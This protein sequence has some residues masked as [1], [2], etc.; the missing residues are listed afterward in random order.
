M[1]TSDTWLNSKNVYFSHERT[2][3]Q[4]EVLRV[5]PARRQSCPQLTQRLLMPPGKQILG[6]GICSFQDGSQCTKHAVCAGLPATQALSGWQVPTTGLYVL[7][8]HSKK[9]ASETEA[10]RMVL[11][12]KILSH[13]REQ[14]CAKIWINMH[15]GKQKLW[16]QTR[17]QSV[18][19]R[20]KV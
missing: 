18:E 7:P 4:Q 10:G 16:N 5:R 14:R 20:T 3:K 15:P 1:N 8:N 19:M 9:T 17:K 11:E 13:R 2:Q 6:K 12:C